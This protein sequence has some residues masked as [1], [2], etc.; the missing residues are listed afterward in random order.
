MPHHRA[1]V[2]VAALFAV[3]TTACAPGPSFGEPTTAPLPTASVAP[4]TTSTPPPPPESTPETGIPQIAP[5]DV[6][7]VSPEDL[8]DLGRVAGQVAIT[9]ADAAI[10]SGRTTTPLDTG[11]LPGQPTWSRDGSRLAVVSLVGRQ[12]TLDVFD[13]AT[14]SLIS[15][16]DIERLYFFL[17]W[18]HDGSR[19]AG[20]G[21][22]IDENGTPQTVLDILDADGVIVHAE[23]ARASS[24]F[25]AWE[26][27]GLRLAAH[28]DERLLRIDAD[29][30]NTD[31]GP[32]GLEFFAPKW[33]PTTNEIL[34]VT[35]IESSPFIVR[36][37]IDGGDTLKTLGEATPEMGITVHP[38][39][40]VAAI[41][42]TFEAEGG[43]AADRIE[44]PVLPQ[45]AEGRSGTV[46]IIGLE[47][48]DRVPVFTGFTL[49]MEWNPQ[50][51]HLLIY[52]AD[53]GSG[54]G[55]WWVYE[56]QPELDGEPIPAVEIVTFSPTPIF[57]GSYISFSDQFI[58]SPRLWSP[59]GREFT[60]AELT[61]AGSLI[62]TVSAT[63]GNEPA[64]IG[65]GE[66][67][68][69]SPAG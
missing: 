39:G 5:L 38:D 33:I 1:W 63:G 26:P 68:F 25:V 6:F 37:S 64:T 31:L 54:T 32:V 30:T 8:T 17:S 4:P 42:Q 35:D 48:G 40:A 51:T 43:G 24:L 41:S 13:A 55:T 18:S 19:I 53:V 28:A 21:P 60:Y 56:H 16:V 47:S 57:F 29:G 20:L 7:P 44:L 67:G 36:R 50:G 45:F 11:A 34:L 10:R 23:V 61:D 49:W 62:R 2:V 46:E 14:G 65:A 12:P 3:V 27:G 59:N 22:G 15:S 69:W 58:E 52:E 66:V 9:G